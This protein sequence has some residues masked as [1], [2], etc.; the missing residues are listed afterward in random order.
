MEKDLQQKLESFQRDVVRQGE[1]IVFHVFPSK[2]RVLSIPPLTGNR[3]LTQLLQSMD[4]SS[5]PFHPSHITGTTDPTVYPAPDLN[6]GAAK[7]RKLDEGEEKISQEIATPQVESLHPR[8]PE[9]VKGNHF[10]TL[11]L[12]KKL[13]EECEVLAKLTDQVRLWVALTMP[14][15]EDG[16]NFGVGVQ[17][18]VLGE[19]HRAQE[20]SFNLRDIPMQ[21]YLARAKICSKLIK[22]PNIE[23]YTHLLDIRNVYATSTDMV[24]KNISK[25][26]KPKGDNSIGLY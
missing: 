26:R 18:E 1:D 25:I 7:K 17:E 14:K 9:L 2:S 13:K 23:D 21:S 19:L 11:S 15:I 22:Y 12:H 4:E 20:A 10:V 6:D 24:H 16:D 8:Y 3:E 5:S